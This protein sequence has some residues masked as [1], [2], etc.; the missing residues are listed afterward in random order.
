MKIFYNRKFSSIFSLVSVN[1]SLK[2]ETGFT[3]THGVAQI[4]PP[5]HLLKAFIL[6]NET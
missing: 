5:Q 3:Y 2:E 1:F 6:C 4:S